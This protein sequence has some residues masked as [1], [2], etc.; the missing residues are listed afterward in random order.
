VAWKRK[1]ELEK[2]MIE[3]ASDSNAGN[4]GILDELFD[5]IKGRQGAAV[6]SSYTARLFAEGEGKIAQKL[7]EEAVECVVA[8][9][10]QEP[11]DLINE[12]ADLLYHLLVLWAVKDIT[13]E[14]VYA[15]LRRR[16]A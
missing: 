7:G 12:S 1:S 4:A 8:A 5:V 11:K 6:E 14:D 16:R 2:I 10:A 9:L 13:P 3:T 15:E